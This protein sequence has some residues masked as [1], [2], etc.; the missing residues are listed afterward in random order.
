M[1][2]VQERFRR[3]VAAVAADVE[4]WHQDA[5]EA[6]DRIADGAERLRRLSEAWEIFESLPPTLTTSLRSAR[7]AARTLRSREITMPFRV[8]SGSG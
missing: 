7:S 2:D 6:K 8:L 1:A 5:L 3:E 4:K